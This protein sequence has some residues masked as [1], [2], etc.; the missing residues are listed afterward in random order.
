[1]LAALERAGYAWGGHRARTFGRRDFEDFDLIIPQDEANR[2]DI[3]ALA[4]GADA[5][6]KVL[7]M[8][9][10]F[11][12]GE[13]ERSVPDPYYGGPAGFDAVVQLLERSMPRLI[14]YVQQQLA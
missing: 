12:A 11:A 8:S 2:R 13:K 3:L 10:W 7:P 4:P 1:M 14:A 6:A 5:A 9:H